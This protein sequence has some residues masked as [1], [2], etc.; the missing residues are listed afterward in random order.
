MDFKMTVTSKN[1]LVGFVRRDASTY[2][3]FK[4]GV[5][6]GYYVNKSSFYSETEGDEGILP[7]YRILKNAM[8]NQVDGVYE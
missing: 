1:S 8:D 7:A 6:Q 3:V 5:Y 4:N 2:Y